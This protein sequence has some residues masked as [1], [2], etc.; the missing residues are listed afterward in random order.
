[1]VFEN[2]MK[3]DRETV[4]ALQL[5]II[6]EETKFERRASRRG[7]IASHRSGVIVQ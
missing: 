2:S 5:K 7:S 1:M 3:A 4:P 6:E